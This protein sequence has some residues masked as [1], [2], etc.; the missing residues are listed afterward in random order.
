MQLCIIKGSL[1]TLKLLLLKSRFACEVR[2]IILIQIVFFQF[3]LLL[4]ILWKAYKSRGIH[5]LLLHFF[6]A[7]RLKNCWVF[8]YTSRLWS[9]LTQRH[10]DVTYKLLRVFLPTGFWSRLTTTL[11]NLQWFW[12][13]CCKSKEWDI[14]LQ[15][16]PR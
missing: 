4:T 15:F 14:F 10:I 11:L 5:G 1:A 16:W 3:K 2:H 13:I 12:Y 8:V 9:Y 6:L 7:Q